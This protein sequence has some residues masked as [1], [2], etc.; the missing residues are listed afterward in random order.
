MLRF[1]D[2]EPLEGHRV[3]V[4]L[5][6]G[7]ER[8]LDLEP[9]LWGPAFEAIAADRSL[10]GQVYVDERTRTLAWPNGAD[11][12]PDVLLSASRPA[13]AAPRN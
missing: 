8:D 3:H 12:D 10:F 11:L 6:D 1:T 5:T 7:T 13:S 9:Y 4:R 2:V